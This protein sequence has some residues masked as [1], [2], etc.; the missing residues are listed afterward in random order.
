MTLGAET[1][2]SY[3]QDMLGPRPRGGHIELHGRG[4]RG[5]AQERGRGRRE[6]LV[7]RQD[8]RGRG[9]AR[10]TVPRVGDRVIA[11][12]VGPPVPR[13]RP[14]LDEEIG[15]VPDGAAPAVIGA[16]IDGEQT[17]VV[18]WAT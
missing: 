5:E 7:V 9:A 12:K 15:D 8:E 11:D 17:A 10:R 16:L 4:V 14:H 18:D 13:P 6:I 3:N 1:V 2:T